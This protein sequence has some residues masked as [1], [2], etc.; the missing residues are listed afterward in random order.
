MNASG[1]AVSLKGH[2]SVVKEVPTLELLRREQVG[3]ALKFA[4]KLDP[5][6]LGLAR[7]GAVLAFHGRHQR[8]QAMGGLV[9]RLI[10]EQLPQ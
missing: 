3:L 10:L 1:L 5:R 6:H 2:D 9:F 7:D 8:E 4:D